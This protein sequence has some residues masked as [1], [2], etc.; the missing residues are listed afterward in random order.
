MGELVRRSPVLA[1]ALLTFLA[2]TAA[3][4]AEVGPLEGPNVQSSVNKVKPGLRGNLIVNLSA[5]R[6]PLPASKRPQPNAQRV[7]LG[8]LPAIPFE[9]VK[10]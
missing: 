10:R 6:Q 4:R 5:Q 8:T 9:I 3:P 2:G 1:A 7:Q